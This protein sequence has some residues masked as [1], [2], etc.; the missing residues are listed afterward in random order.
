MTAV[1]KAPV[2]LLAA[3]LA[4]LY[5]VCDP[6]TADLAAQ[7]YRTELFQREGFAL[8]DTGWYAGHALPGYSTLFPPAAALLGPRVAAAIAMVIAT[9][10]FE[11]LTEHRL[12]TA[13]F[14][15]GMTS[16]LF[17]GRLTFV[18]GAAIGVGALLALRHDRRT[19]AIALAVA[20]SL[21]SPVAGLFL[22]LCGAAYAIDRRRPL[23]AAIAAAAIAPVLILGLVFEGGG[24][25][26]FEFDAF[27]PG[28]LATVLLFALIPRSHCLLRIGVALNALLLLCA[29]TFDTQVGGNAMR[30][31]S[32]AAA[33]IAA[34]ALLDKRRLAFALILPALLFWQWSSAI[35]DWVRASGDDSVHAAYY[36]PLLGFLD[37]QDTPLRIEIPFTD[38]HWDATHVGLRYPLAR[39]WERQ[40]DRKLN[41]M[42]YGSKDFDSAEYAR[43]LRDNAVSF[44]A[45]PDAPL[46]YSAAHE[47]RLIRAGQPYLKPVFR[48]AH[49]RVFAVRDPAPLL[50]GGKL[51]SV[52]TD[53]IT[54]RSD[55]AGTARLRFRWT[56][57]WRI[58]EGTGCVERDGDW[59]KLALRGAGRVELTTTFTPGRIGASGAACSGVSGD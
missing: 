13:L 17:S 12:A 34:I 1:R 26:P 49:W 35:D 57:Y 18:L 27:I 8:W 30:L 32:L 52:T 54:L 23:G 50:T 16:M 33:S 38:N 51:L 4:L 28:F 56:P 2:W 53:T 9:A 44:V 24:T 5:Y 43:W 11:R 48:S 42:F 45:L 40:A 36:A 37:R 39:G 20:T 14:A 29:F 25:F 59:T 19:V 10:L 31:G 7:V 55:G 46:D 58:S 41:P 22:A 47:A 6:R 15:T 3:G 21:G